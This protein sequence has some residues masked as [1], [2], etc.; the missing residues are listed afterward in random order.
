VILYG[1]F[2]RGGWVDDRATGY[3]SDYDILVVVDHED[4]TDMIDY[5]SR[6][7]QRLLQ[8]YMFTQQIRFPVGLIVHTF[9]DVNDQLRRG[10]PFFIDAM[11]DGIALYEAPGHVFDGPRPLTPAE[12]LEEAQGYF[13]EWFTSAEEFFDNY[14]FSSELHRNKNAA[15]QLHQAIERLYHGTLLVLKLYTPRSHD[16]EFLRSRA[17]AIDTRLVPAWPRKTRF[18]QDRFGLLR[19]AYVEARYSKHY[20]ITAEE[21]AW[22]G[23]RVTVLRDLVETVCKEHLATMRDQASGP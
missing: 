22:I 14:R 16:I 21:L 10:R 9:A 11:R 23:A 19:R 5:W 4:L 20:V 6:F 15:F 8:D 3:K 1:S 2:A 12:T 17:E 7:E 18:D 13:D